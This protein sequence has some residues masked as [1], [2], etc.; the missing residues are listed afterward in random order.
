MF[1]NLTIMFSLIHQPI[2]AKKSKCTIHTVSSVFDLARTTKEFDVHSTTDPC[3]YLD[4]EKEKEQGLNRRQN[5]SES[6]GTIDGN[7][8]VQYFAGKVEKGLFNDVEQTTLRYDVDVVTKLIVYSGEFCVE[9][10]RTE[11]M[12]KSRAPPDKC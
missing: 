7:S 2:F 4:A 1:G 3:E 8:H 9:L 5:K 10:E 11:R 6:N 12:E